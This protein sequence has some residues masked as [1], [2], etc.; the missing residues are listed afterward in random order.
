MSAPSGDARGCQLAGWQTRLD[1]ILRKTVAMPHLAP[2]LLLPFAG[3]RAAAGVRG[4]QRATLGATASRVWPG[5]HAVLRAF[6]QRAFAQS[7]WMAALSQPAVVATAC[8]V[9]A[10]SQCRGSSC[11]LSLNLS[12]TFCPCG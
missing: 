4:T 2:P 6:A 10:A 7:L 9:M 1:A 11:P 5:H 3:L 8:P 12:P